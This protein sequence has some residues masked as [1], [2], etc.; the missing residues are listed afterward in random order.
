MSTLSINIETPQS[1]NEK[2]YGQ[3]YSELK[4]QYL[5]DQY[6]RKSTARHNLMSSLPS[7]Q[8]KK[9]VTKIQGK[10]LV[11]EIKCASKLTQ[12]IHTRLA[13]YDAV[14]HYFVSIP[15]PK[16]VDL[17]PTK[18][19]VDGKFE[20]CKYN[21]GLCPHESILCLIDT[22]SGWGLYLSERYWNMSKNKKIAIS[23]DIVMIMNSYNCNSDSDVQL[24]M[25]IFED[26]MTHAP[27]LATPITN[28]SQS[29]PTNKSNIDNKLP[30]IT[31]AIDTLIASE[32]EFM[33]MDIADLNKMDR[34]RP[35]VTNL[36]FMNAYD[37]LCSF[38]YCIMYSIIEIELIRVIQKEKKYNFY[39]TKISVDSE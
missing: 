9:Q 4:A 22:I 24:E 28:T 16:N 35:V 2:S 39:F 11:F 36:G 19:T 8:I 33:I 23:N 12:Y 3:R 31:R 14:K 30:Q 17:T 13:Q 32:D 38:K 37:I 20:C 27:I 7:H 26:K 5:K 1:H 18:I 34:T 29:V 10:Y 21:E 15:T 25:V 6:D